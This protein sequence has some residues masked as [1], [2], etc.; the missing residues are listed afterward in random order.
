M[1][2]VIVLGADCVKCKIW[3]VAS[4]AAQHSPFCLSNT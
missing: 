3:S 4:T 1:N 2:V